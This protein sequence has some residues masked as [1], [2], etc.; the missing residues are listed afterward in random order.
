MKVLVIDRVD[1][2]LPEGLRELGFEVVEDY[3]TPR[4]LMLKKLQ[5]INGLVIR[6]RFPIDAEVLDAF[7]QLKFIGRVGAGMENI[8]L[9]YA[10]AK[11]VKCMRAAD[12]NRTAVGEHALGMLLMLLNNLRRADREVRNGI[13]RRE[14]NRGYELEGRTVAIIGYGEMGSA[15][16]DKLAGLGVRVL[17]YDLYKSGFGQGHVQEADMSEIFQE[18]DILSLHVPETELT[19]GMVDQQ[20]LQSFRKSIY[21]VNTSRGKVV[22]TSAL[23]EAMRSGKVLGACLDVLEYEK[24]SFENFFETSLPDDFQ[25]L[26]DSDRTVLSP[27]IAGWTHESGAKMARS[28]LRQI[29]EF[30]AG[31]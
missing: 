26:V 23:V 29:K 5:D 13:W 10:A 1:S 9:D 17:A 14:E 18:A 30:K 2:L 25:Y 11:G 27:H 16:A 4:D 21:L 28:I 31:V 7:P 24:S 15:F 3:D 20:Y 8:D 12:G 19:L 6:S 22:S